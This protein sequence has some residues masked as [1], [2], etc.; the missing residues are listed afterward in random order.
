MCLIWLNSEFSSQPVKK[1]C[2][3]YYYNEFSSCFDFLLMEQTVFN[4]ELQLGLIA[5]PLETRA[6]TVKLLMDE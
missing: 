3:S 2:I 6:D 5:D 1:E 4:Y